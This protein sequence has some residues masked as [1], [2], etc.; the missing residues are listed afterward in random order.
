MPVWATEFKK[1]MRCLRHKMPQ[2]LIA[3]GG[4]NTEGRVQGY[5]EPN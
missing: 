5:G 3:G 4:E 2:K 1:G